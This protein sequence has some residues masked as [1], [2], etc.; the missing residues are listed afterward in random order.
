MSAKN[1]L[2]S[3]FQVAVLAASATAAVCA[4]NSGAWASDLAIGERVYNVPG[5]D[6]ATIY[7]LEGNGTFVLRFESGDLAGQTGGGW[8]RDDLAILRGCSGDLCV[9]ANVVNV[10]RNDF[11]RVVGLQTSGQ[12]VLEFT[13]GDLNG[14]SGSG[15]NR[16]DLAVERGCS[17]SGMFCVGRSAF[18]VTRSE[19][20][21]IIA[22]EQ[23]GQ[24]ILRFDDGD[25]AGQI[26][27][28]WNESDLAV[29]AQT[30][31]QPPVIVQ[32][33]PVGRPVTCTTVS[34]GIRFTVTAPELSQARLGVVNRCF[35]DPRTDKQECSR[36]S[37]CNL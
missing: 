28:G 7:G 22:I 12:Y 9:G 8:S 20:V 11:A 24:M 27:G 14:Q 15:W 3:S 13:S 5:G 29:T 2:K 34:R 21:T 10:P 1:L 19:N 30:Q 23:S 4:L 25:L 36:A 37:T 33:G 26:G 16:G 6:Y 32:P 17:P 18:N 31:P 35:A